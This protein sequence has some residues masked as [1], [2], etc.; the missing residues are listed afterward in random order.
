MIKVYYKAS[1]FHYHVTHLTDNSQSQFLTRRRKK[2]R[3]FYTQQA[4]S[5]ILTGSR[6]KRIARGEE[7]KVRKSTGKN[8]HSI[9]ERYNH[10]RKYKEKE[11]F[12][13]CIPKH[14][15]SVR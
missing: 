8:I 7:R 9:L 12:R 2:E 15:K 11:N 4:L 3:I 6:V 10:K 1:K 14:F 5:R 13:I